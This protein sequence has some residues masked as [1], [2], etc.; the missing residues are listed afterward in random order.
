MVYNNNSIVPWFRDYQLKNDTQHLI[1]ILLIIIGGSYFCS[2]ELFF[3]K[4][5]F[6]RKIKI[7]QKKEIKLN[8]LKKV[9]YFRNKTD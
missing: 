9:L 1:H 5:S 8:F 4:F 3:K 7:L 2:K 6:I